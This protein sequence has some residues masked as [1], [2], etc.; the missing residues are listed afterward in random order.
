[1]YCL[2]DIVGVQVREFDLGDLVE[3]IDGE[4]LFEFVT[5]WYIGVFGC[6]DFFEDQYSCGRCFGD[7][8]E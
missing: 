6:V 4:F 8:V 3:L 2:V 1:M 7:E 5:V